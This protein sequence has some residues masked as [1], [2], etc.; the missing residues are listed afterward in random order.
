MRRPRRADRSHR[1]GRGARLQPQCGLV[2]R[3]RSGEDRAGRQR[4]GCAAPPCRGARHRRG[5]LSRDA[6]RTPAASADPDRGAVL[7][8]ASARGRADRRR[9]RS[10]HA[11]G[12]PAART[13]RRALHLRQHRLCARREIR[14][15]QYRLP[16]ADVARI[17]R[18]RHRPQRAERPARALPGRGR[19]GR[20]AARRVRRGQPSRRFSRRRRGD[21]AD[22]RARGGRGGPRRAAAGGEMRDRGRQGAS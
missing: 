14:C 1:C 19:E 11:A 22:R 9:R 5:G 8:G 15:Y 2:P 17:A 12:A 10:D 20:E 6:T 13:R 4:D 16:P 21:A 3:G 18:R 7:A